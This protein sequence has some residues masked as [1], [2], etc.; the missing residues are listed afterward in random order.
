[1]LCSQYSSFHDERFNRSGLVEEG[2][3]WLSRSVWWY[4]HHPKTIDRFV[5]IV[6]LRDREIV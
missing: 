1:M 5:D 2:F 3:A 6:V 4:D